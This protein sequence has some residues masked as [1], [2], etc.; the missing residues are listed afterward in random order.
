MDPGW[1]TMDTIKIIIPEIV[2][3]HNKIENKLIKFH[4]KLWTYCSILEASSIYEVIGNLICVANGERYSV[5]IFPNIINKN[6]NKSR[7]QT[8]NEK[9]IQIKKWASGTKY[10]DAV[11]IYKD[12]WDQD[13]RNATYH[14]DYTIHKD[15]MRLFNSKKNG[16]YKIFQVEEL[17]MKAL[18]YYESFFSL[19]EHYLKSYEKPVVLKLHPDCS[20]WPGEWEVIIH[21]GNGARGIQNKRAKE[22]ILNHVLVQRVAHITKQQ[23]KYLRDNPYTAIIPEDII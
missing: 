11:K 19:Y 12:I 3:V 16:I 4:L 23:E 14:S 10:F 8:P 13:I 1:D 15:E 2:D 18:A 6:N 5:N 17:A 22:D 21:E 20:D 9:I 7:P